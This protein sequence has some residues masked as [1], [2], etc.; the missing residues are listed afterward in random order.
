MSYQVT[1]KRPGR[2]PAAHLDPQTLLKEEL[3]GVAGVHRQSRALLFSA[4]EKLRK[5]MEVID[6]PI[7]LAE[8]AQKVASIMGDAN[9]SVETLSKHLALAKTP[10]ATPAGEEDIEKLM[11][12]IV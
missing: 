10:T 9:K 6:D 12:E 1:G 7:T 3:R 2:P 11:K 4:L 5:Q 8:L